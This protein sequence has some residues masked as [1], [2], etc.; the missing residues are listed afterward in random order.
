MKLRAFAFSLSIL[1][2]WPRGAKAALRVQQNRTVHRSLADYYHTLTTSTLGGPNPDSAIGNPLKGLVESPFYNY[3]PYK[4]DIP[5]SVE[6]YYIGTYHFLCMLIDVA[7]AH[8]HGRDLSIGL[9]DIMKGNPRIVGETKAFDWGLLDDCLQ[10]SAGRNNHAIWRV[11]VHF[12]GQALKVPKY[13]IDAGVDLRRY[14]GGVSPY[15]GDPKLLEAFEQFIKSSGK[16]YDGDKRL[17]FVQAGLLGFWGEW[18]TFGENFIPSGVGEKVVAWYAASYTKTQVQLRYPS[19]SGFSA[20]LGLHDDSFAYETL[21]GQYNGGLVRSYFFWPS[22]LR[23]GGGDSWKR[24]AVGG[25]TRPEIQNEVFEPGY[26]SGTAYKQNF[27]QCVQICHVTYMF[28]HAAFIGSGFTGTELANARSAHARMG[29]NFHV[30]SVAVKRLANANQVDVDVTMQQIGVAPFYYD[31]GLAIKCDGMPPKYVGGVDSL[32]DNGESKVF[33]FTNIPATKTCLDALTLTLESS[34]AYPGKP[35]KFA[36]GNGSLRF[37][38]PLPGG[39]GP[40]G[41]RPSPVQSPVSSGSS[42][43]LTLVNA[44]SDTD[45]GRLT[46]GAVINL[47]VYP[48]I[49][50]RAIPSASTRSIVF[51]LNGNVFKVCKGP[52]TMLEEY[53]VVLLSHLKLLAVRNK[54]R[55]WSNLCVQWECRK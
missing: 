19:S 54:D 2:S 22:V 28:H 5:N 6:F 38:L 32:I 21:D 1:S 48:R 9:D 49:N 31:L 15:Y 27:M 50:V 12:P 55:Q 10:K 41:P 40:I 29:Y 35:I 14:D 37:S 51:K 25:E 4:V 53:M 3:P 47:A 18:H 34:Y 33:G 26:K 11:I 36:Q 8:N 16:R 7:W 24:A 13:L 46:N 20:G 52:R 43:T 39:T 23:S 42:V 45:I 30:F 17:G 44:D